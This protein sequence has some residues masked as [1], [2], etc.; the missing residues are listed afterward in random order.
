MLK[1]LA[2]KR[3]AAIG[4][5]AATVVMAAAGTA[6]AGT[7]R[8][9]GEAFLS[10]SGTNTVWTP[11][12]GSASLLYPGGDYM[13]M[14]SNGKIYTDEYFGQ[15]YQLLTLS[16]QTAGGGSCFHPAHAVVT[17][18]GK[19]VINTSPGW[20]PGNY[21]NSNNGVAQKYSIGW[22]RIAIS[23]D[24]DAYIAGQCDVN[25]LVDF[26]QRSSGS[27]PFGGGII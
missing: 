26:V 14:L 2:S 5:I 17:V 6:Q 9:Q 1:L 13:A 11:A 8:V 24:N 18:D 4:A 27:Q 20:L 16:S 19:E 21:A 22:H 15:P 7:T 12:P 10:A 23:F 3:L 25:L